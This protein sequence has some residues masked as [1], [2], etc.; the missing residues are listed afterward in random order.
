MAAQP[1]LPADVLTPRSPDP[2][3]NLPRQLTSFVGRAREIAEV[4]RLIASSPL[5]T[6][7]G[8]GGVGKTRL[9][10]RVA[11]EGLASFPDGVWLVDLG[12]LAEPTLVPRAIAT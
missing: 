11:G 8:A 2:P 9:A 10:L 1:D 4:G 7:T 3:N 5:V 12:P 6:L